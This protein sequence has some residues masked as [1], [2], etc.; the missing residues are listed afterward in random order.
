M[1]KSLFEYKNS[2]E[3]PLFIGHRGFTPVAPENS[4]PSFE[5]AGKRGFWAIE[6]DV[7]KTRDGV[8]VCCHN[9]SMLKMYGE[10]IVIEENDLSE[11]MKLRLCRGNGLSDYSEDELRIP[12]FSEYIDI[13][14]KYGAVP[15]IESKAMIA[16][17]ILDYVKKEDL[18]EYSVFSSVSFEHIKAAAEVNKDVFL[19]HIFS[20]E[21]YARILAER[22]NCGLSYNYPDLSL[23]PEGLIEFTHDLGVKVCLRAGDTV[24]KCFEMLDLGLDY[25]PTNKIYSLDQN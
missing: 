9:A 3:H 23:L 10:D 1:V 6:T 21:E 11:I 25:I 19:H 13:C 8:L 16:E 24:E 7:H 4:L 20:N 18:I 17:E 12:L 15:F 5:A 2:R 14:K 22:G